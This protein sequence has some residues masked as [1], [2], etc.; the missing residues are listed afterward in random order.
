MKEK[1]VKEVLEGSLR[2]LQ[3]RGWT[4]GRMYDYR[5][6][7]VCAVGAVRKAY[8]N[9]YDTLSEGDLE[10]IEAIAYLVAEVGRVTGQRVWYGE[11]TIESWNDAPDRSHEDVVLLFKNAIE[12]AS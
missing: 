4:Q 12:N 3:A 5:T 1:T 11:G 8:F 6:G 9:H 2:E 10:Y 7:S